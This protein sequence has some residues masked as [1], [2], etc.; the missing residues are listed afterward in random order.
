MHPRGRKGVECLRVQVTDE[1]SSV[2]LSFWFFDQRFAMG[3]FWTE[4]GDPG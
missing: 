1:V 3:R 4:D 2:D